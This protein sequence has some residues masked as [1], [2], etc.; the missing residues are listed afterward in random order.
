MT[1]T[2]RPK[3]VF[4]RGAVYALRF[5]VPVELRP[6]VG[7]RE[8]IRS[9]GSSDLGEA[10]SRRRE[11]LEEIKARSSRNTTAPK[12]SAHRRHRKTPPFEQ[13]PTAGWPRVT[14]SSLRPSSA[15]DVSSNASRHSPAMPRSRRSPAAWPSPTWTT[16][17]RHPRSAPASPSR[18]ARCPHTSLASPPTGAS[19]TTGVLSIPTCPIPSRRSCGAWRGKRR[20]RTRGPRTCAR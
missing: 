11:T 16:S 2:V 5:T 4:K 9:L 10:L 13:P 20:R 17:A 18:N 15:I 14:A 12:R 19:S 7:K 6:A 8:I 1:F 3:G